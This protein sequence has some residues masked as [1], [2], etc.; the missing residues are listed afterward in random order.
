MVL[1]ALEDPQSSGSV[2][3]LIPTAMSRGSEI[4][5]QVDNAWV[6]ANKSPPSFPHAPA[7]LRPTRT[8]V[9]QQ[10]RVCYDDFRIRDR[11]EMEGE[12]RDVVSQIGDVLETIKP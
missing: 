12:V 8:F 6:G 5:T 9:L 10:V 7:S 11:N 2:R 3:H 1:H 4:P